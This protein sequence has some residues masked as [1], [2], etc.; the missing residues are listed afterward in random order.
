MVLSVI[1]AH[2]QVA[3]P[4]SNLVHVK[5]SMEPWTLFVYGAE[6]WESEQQNH[7]ETLASGIDLKLLFIWPHH[8]TSND[9]GKH[10]NQPKEVMK[11]LLPYEQAPLETNKGI[12]TPLSPPRRKVL[13]EGKQTELTRF[14]LNAAS[15]KSIKTKKKVSLISLFFNHQFNFLN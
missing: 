5:N 15:L 9:W 6:K 1:S 12:R 11:W 2:L 13:T 14:Q 3:L 4:I 7:R 10:A 8:T